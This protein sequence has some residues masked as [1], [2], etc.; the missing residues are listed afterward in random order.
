MCRREVINFL[1]AHAIMGGEWLE[2]KRIRNVR[3]VN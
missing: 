2:K 1:L 3:R